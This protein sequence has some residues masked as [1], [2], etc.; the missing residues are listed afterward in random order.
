MTAR[1]R[2]RNKEI[3]SVL[4][5]AR[6]QHGLTIITCAKYIA[7]T[8]R[9]YRAIERGDAAVHAAELEALMQALQ[10]SRLPSH[11]IWPTVECLGDGTIEVQERAE[12]QPPSEI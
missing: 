8:P 1:L 2:A 3:G 6:Q 7:T 4:A 9:R 10:I 11:V 5:T 12:V